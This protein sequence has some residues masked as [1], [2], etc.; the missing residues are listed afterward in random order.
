MQLQQDFDLRGLTESHQLAVCTTYAIMP[1]PSEG[2]GTLY[3]F[4]ESVK[5]SAE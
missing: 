1:V 4:T 5:K 3:R 2:S